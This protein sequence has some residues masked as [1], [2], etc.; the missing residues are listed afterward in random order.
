L[1]LL[2]HVINLLLE[3]I[4]N[5]LPFLLKSF[6][7]VLDIVKFVTTIANNV[8]SVRKGAWVCAFKETLETLTIK[9]SFLSSSITSFDDI[10]KVLFVK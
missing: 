6:N 2:S 4:V 7:Q 1:L 9:V 5:F 10:F 8:E 3:L